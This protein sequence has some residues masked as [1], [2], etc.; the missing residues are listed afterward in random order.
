MVIIRENRS[1][2]H[3]A[4]V[5]CVD[6][7]HSLGRTVPLDMPAIMPT[8]MAAEFIASTSL[9]SQGQVRSV[10]VVSSSMVRAM[11]NRGL[12]LWR[13]AKARVR[14]EVSTG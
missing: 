10:G 6:R 12:L 9:K 2:G 4:W 14:R 3:V 13:L 1:T 5:A 8:T 11:F 7:G